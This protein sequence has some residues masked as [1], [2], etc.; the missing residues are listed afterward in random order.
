MSKKMELIVFD[1]G[2]TLDTNGIHCSEKCWEV[3]NHCQIIISKVVFGN[4]FV[5]S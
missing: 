3:Y 1:F 2:G 5:Y 4:A